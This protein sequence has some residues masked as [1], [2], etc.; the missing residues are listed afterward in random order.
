M[1]LRRLRYFA[2][3]ADEGGISRAAT[4][5]H[6]AQPAL[7][8]QIHELE[9]AVGT[10]LFDRDNR[11]VQLTSA[12]VRLRE[13]V[14]RVL[15]RLEHTVRRV[16]LA[17]EGKLA[18]LRLGLSRGALISRR[19]GRVILAFRE[20]YPD[21][22][23]LVREVDLWAQPQALKSDEVDAAIGLGSESDPAFLSATFFE[24][25]VDSALFATSH[26]LAAPGPIDPHELMDEQLRLDSVSL[27]LLSGLPEGLERLGFRWEEVEGL[28]TVYSHVA[29]GNGWT[30]T[31]SSAHVDA[32]AGL[33]V[34]PI[35]GMDVPLPMVLRWRKHDDLPVLKNL[36]AIADRVSASG[37]QYERSI[38]EGA[39][40]ADDVDGADATARTRT[41]EV[42]HLVAL[43]T[44]L[45]AGSLSAAAE[46]LERTQSAISRQIRALERAVGVPLIAR[47]GQRL[48]ATAAG[49][50]L[51]DEAPAILELLDTALERPRRTVLGMTGRCAIGT[52]PRELTNGLLVDVLRQLTERYPAVTITVAEGPLREPLLAGD[53]DLAL[54]ARFP[55]AVD[56]PSITS[57]VLQED[58][59]MC[60]LIS[61][62]H[63]LAARATLSVADLADEPLLFVSRAF[64]PIAYDLIIRELRPLGL[65]AGIGADYDGARAIWRAVASGGGWTIGPRSLCGAP[66]AGIVARPIDGVSIPWGIGLQWRRGET[67]PVVLRVAEIF[68]AH[69]DVAEQLRVPA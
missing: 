27:S 32:P 25:H 46:Q 45:N 2:T 29:A 47:I 67:D 40:P 49:A 9:R 1:I 53:I 11:G 33:V 69:A 64:S 18:T 59:L 44:S 6:V 62:S 35:R 23:L 26:R 36:A 51:R 8:R 4:K 42:P 50:V 43:V 63:P 65:G 52:M 38:R 24:E 55:G 20:Q 5:L 31:M 56:H 68:R 66:P 7:T 22:E 37:V 57:V 30:V 41:V 21:V 16:H 19:V 15:A 34:R 28:D 14:E 58:P 12:G 3:V 54:V 61:E 60:A 17:H 39:A 13:D 48:I 10:A